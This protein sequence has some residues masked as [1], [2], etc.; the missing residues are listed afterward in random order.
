MAITRAQQ[1]RQM[2]EKGG[3]LGLFRG[4]L[5]DTKGGK[6][7]SPGTSADYSPGQGNRQDR[8]NRGG[9]PGGGDPKMKYTAPPKDYDRSKDTGP[10]RFKLAEQNRIKKEEERRRKAEEDRKRMAEEK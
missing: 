4:A 9:P 5:A 3:R 1:V 6:A 7:M 8:E 10:D 2:L